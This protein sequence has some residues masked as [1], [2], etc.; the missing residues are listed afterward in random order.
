MDER[1]EIRLHLM[2]L[3]A[4]FDGDLERV[5]TL[6]KI[7]QIYQSHILVESERVEWIFSFSSFSLERVRVLR[8]EEFGDVIHYLMVLLL[9]KRYK[10]KRPRS[11]YNQRILFLPTPQKNPFEERMKEYNHHYP[12]VPVDRC[13]FKLSFT[14]RDFVLKAR[15]IS[16]GSFTWFRSEEN[17][18]WFEFQHGII[19]IYDVTRFESLTIY[20]SHGN[21][22]EIDGN[23]L[24]KENGRLDLSGYVHPDEVLLVRAVVDL[25]VV[26][27][28]QRKGRLK[29]MSESCCKFDLDPCFLEYHSKESFPF[30]YRFYIP[31]V[32]HLLNVERMVSGRPRKPMSPNSLEKLASGWG[33]H[34]NMERLKSLRRMKVDQSLAHPVPFF[35]IGKKPLSVVK[36]S[37]NFLTLYQDDYSLAKCT[38]Q[39]SK[40]IL[41]LDLIESH[42]SRVLPFERIY[43][44]PLY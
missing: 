29:I 17:E 34:E 36:E 9:L 20:T 25:S 28:G 6:E 41:K 18:C 27:P 5:A 37:E 8:E 21:G 32:D 30:P 38:I 14:L 42:E 11:E 43:R 2:K 22:I 24:M 26:F 16:S 10:R 3:D 33:F 44:Y 4:R 7:L 19:F 13:N 39:P 31:D 15:E 35:S 1:R 23:S 12:E 40:G